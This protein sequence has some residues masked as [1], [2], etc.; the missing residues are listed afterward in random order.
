MFADRSESSPSEVA[1]RLLKETA[2]RQLHRQVE[3]TAGSGGPGAWFRRGMQ[4]TGGLLANLGDGLAALAGPLVVVLNRK[5]VLIGIAVV[6]LSFLAS[7]LEFDYVENRRIHDQLSASYAQ[8][9]ALQQREVTEVSA[10]ELEQIQTETLAWLEPT[11]E[12]LEAKAVRKPASKRYW[13]GIGSGTARARWNLLGAAKDL[14][15]MVEQIAVP[16]TRGEAF[17]RKMD[18][19]SDDMSGASPSDSDPEGAD[20]AAG[21]DSTMITVLAIDAVLVA[22]GLLYWIRRRRE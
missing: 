21:L 6:I 11:I 1:S 5:V 22:G 2:L 3:G 16:T 7:R 15:A 20:Q 18:K 10:D 4:G 9:E 14:Q 8:L 12:S 13:F 19:A 17:A